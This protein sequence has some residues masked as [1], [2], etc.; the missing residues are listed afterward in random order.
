MKEHAIGIDVG[1]TKIAAGIVD[2]GGRIRKRFVTRAHTE[3][4]PATVIACILDAYRGLLLDGGIAEADLQGV[5]VGFGGT[6]NGHTGTVLVSSNLPAWDHFPLR[7]TISPCVIICRPGSDR[8][9]CSTMIRIAVPWEST[10]ARY[11]R[12]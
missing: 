6:V 7:G 1:G 5:C 3:K 10:V 4:D 9:C 2:R 11:E 8:R 12:L